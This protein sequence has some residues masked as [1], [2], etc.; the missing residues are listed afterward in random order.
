MNMI[1]WAF[2]W[3]RV[4][5]QI[6]LGGILVSYVTWNWPLEAWAREPNTPGSDV[7]MLMSDKLLKKQIPINPHQ[8]GAPLPGCVTLAR[9]RPVQCLIHET[10]QHAAEGEQVLT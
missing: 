2:V 4:R 3:R 6:W 5:T 10:T 1:N 7:E 9:F 8:Q